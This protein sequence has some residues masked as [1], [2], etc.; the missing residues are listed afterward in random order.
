M[1]H[2]QSHT[3]TNIHRHT[4][5]YILYLQ[6]VCVYTCVCVCA[7]TCTPACSC[8]GVR[9][10][11]SQ[12]STLRAFLNCSPWFLR[13]SLTEPVL[14][15]QLQTSGSPSP[16]HLSSWNC[17]YR[18]VSVALPGLLYRCWGSTLKSSGACM[19]IS[20]KSFYI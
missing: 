9:A 20:P 8:S 18:I 12:R 17:I 6:S 15:N 1:I 13:Q 2:T 3:H 4:H 7:L 16:K 19:A 14:T 10:C 11:E 5:T